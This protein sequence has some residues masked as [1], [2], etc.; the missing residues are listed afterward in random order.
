[1]VER[2]NRRLAEHLDRRS[3]LQAHRR[4]R[5]HTDR[6]TAIGAWRCPKA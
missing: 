4:F 1:M 2:F 5:D 6:D 3:Q